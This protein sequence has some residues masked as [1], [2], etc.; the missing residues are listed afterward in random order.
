M[1]LGRKKS[2]AKAT[3]TIPIEINRIRRGRRE[4]AAE[5]LCLLSCLSASPRCSTER[6]AELLR[7]SQ[8]V[9][10]R[11]CNDN[12]VSTRRAL[13]TKEG[14]YHNAAPNAPSRAAM[15]TP[16]AQQEAAPQG[17]KREMSNRRHATISP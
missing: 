13:R 5:G 10:K 1:G 15:A 11:S 14:R 3:A 6:G 9:L 7:S 8:A 2:R 12:R 4:T 16:D 17:V